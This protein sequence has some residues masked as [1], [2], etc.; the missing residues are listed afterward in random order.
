MV[1]PTFPTYKLATTPGILVT[2]FGFIII[3]VDV[4]LIDYNATNACATLS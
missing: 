4:F 3:W 1:I 2:D